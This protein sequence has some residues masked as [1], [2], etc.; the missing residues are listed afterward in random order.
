M[1][2]PDAGEY[3]TSF[4]KAVDLGVTTLEMDVVISKDRKVVVSHDTYF[5]H[6]ITTKPGGDTVT[7]SD[8]RSL[9]LYNMNY[10]DIRKYDVGLKPHSRFPSQQKCLFTNHCWLT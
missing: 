4:V 5:N 3:H 6:E 10:D 1:S 2:G 9:M 8:E 7:E